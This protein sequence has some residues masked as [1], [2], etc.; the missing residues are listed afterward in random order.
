[1]STAWQS[2]NQP[3]FQPRR[4]RS[5]A[6]RL[7]PWYDAYLN[8]AEPNSAYAGT[9]HRL[10]RPVSGVVLWAKTRRDA[11]RLSQQFENRRVEKTYWA[12]V[13][14]EVQPTEGDW[15]DWLVR[16][17]TGLGRVQTCLPGTPRSQRAFTRLRAETVCDSTTP[18]LF[19]G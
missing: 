4:P 3:C 1:M 19:L 2:P 6:Q 14:G 12:L 15:E 5:P 17:D 16:E 18:R 13:E 11:R 8:P 7:K 9:V 10:D